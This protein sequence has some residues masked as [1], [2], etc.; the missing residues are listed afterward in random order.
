VT[1]LD[2]QEGDL[3]NENL[4]EYLTAE[5]RRLVCYSQKIVEIDQ[6]YRFQELNMIANWLAAS[7]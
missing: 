2:I 4:D 7:D 6:L 3:N 5:V 1:E